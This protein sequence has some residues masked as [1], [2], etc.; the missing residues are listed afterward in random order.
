[1][2]AWRRWWEGDAWVRLGLKREEGREKGGELIVERK[3]MGAASVWLV[4]C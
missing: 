4:L 1:M 3:K 2:L